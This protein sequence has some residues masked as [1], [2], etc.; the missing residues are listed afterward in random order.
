MQKN[1]QKRI[2]FFKRG[3]KG[4]LSTACDAW[5]DQQNSEICYLF[6]LSIKTNALWALKYHNEYFDRF[7]ESLKM[8]LLSVKFTDR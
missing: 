4:Y 5:L 2:I 6:D 1:A 7:Y 8:S 3:F